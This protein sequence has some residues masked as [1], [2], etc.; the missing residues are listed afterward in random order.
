MGKKP[1][2]GQPTKAWVEQIKRQ[3]HMGDVQK[4]VGRAGCFAENEI[5][6]CPR[7]PQSSKVFQ[8]SDS[9]GNRSLL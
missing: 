5:E 3:R 9:E 6:M 7:P 2:L 4:N 8:A 1:S